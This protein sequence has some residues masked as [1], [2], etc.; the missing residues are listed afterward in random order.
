MLYFCLK[1]QLKSKAKDEKILEVDTNQDYARVAIPT[2]GL[3]FI[4]DIYILSY[5]K[6]FP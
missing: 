5:I 3:S 4:T 1:L 2:I 6:L